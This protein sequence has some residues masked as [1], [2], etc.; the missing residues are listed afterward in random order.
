MSGNGGTE[1]PVNADARQEV[2]TARQ[3]ITSTRDKVLDRTDPKVSGH[4]GLGPDRPSTRAKC[5]GAYS[6]SSARLPVCDSRVDGDAAM[7][8]SGDRKHPLL[9]CSG[10]LVRSSERASVRAEP[11]QGSRCLGSTASPV[12]ASPI[13][14][15]LPR[16]DTSFCSSV[17]AA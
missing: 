15:V 7:L 13:H 14:A 17:S 3:C 12:D 4:Q 10:S 1:I 16:R 8:I 11:S 6:Q 9:T 2:G 5:T